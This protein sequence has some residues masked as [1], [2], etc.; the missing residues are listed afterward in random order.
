MM[1]GLQSLTVLAP[2]KLN[3]S[4][5]ILGK[6]PDGYHQLDSVM[7][8]VDLYDTLTFV[9][10]SEGVRFSCNDPTL[11]TDEG[12]LVLKAA[13]AFFAHCGISP[14]GLEINL[15]KRIPAQAGL[16]GGS[17]DAAAT[18]VGLNRLYGAG[19]G[20]GELARIGLGIGSDLP[21]CLMG[22][23]ARARGRGEILTPLPLPD[24][25]GVFLIA[26]PAQGMSTRL[27]FQLYSQN[28]PENPR[29]HTEL[30]VTA[31]PSGNM[32][33]VGGTLSNAFEK[34]LHLPDVRKIKEIL[35]EHGALGAAMTGSGTAVAGLFPQEKAALPC[36]E[37][38]CQEVD[39][40]CLARPVPHGPLIVD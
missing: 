32:Q 13:G 34:A 1:S 6:T 20:R 15:T 38:L 21:F 8:T 36:I 40:A 28:K 39:F 19:I 33:A 24:E 37:K 23:I 7:L 4:L 3:L 29:H 12:N 35:L 2:A 11:P 27:A 16:G 30:L 17:A 10:H 31:L 9:K 26:K 14:G 25:L 5:D 18:L 22:G